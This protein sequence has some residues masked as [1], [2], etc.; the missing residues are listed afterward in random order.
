VT[1][2]PELDEQPASVSEMLMPSAEEF[3]HSDR[4]QRFRSYRSG[5]S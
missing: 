2:G 3:L 5:R 1:E 4:D